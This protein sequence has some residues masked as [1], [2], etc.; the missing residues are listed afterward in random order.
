MLLPITII[1]W[2]DASGPPVEQ[3]IGINPESIARIEPA[4]TKGQCNVWCDRMTEPYLVKASAEELIGAI[5]LL[6]SEE[7]EC[8]ADA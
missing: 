4:E 3:Q 7:I 2:L 1:K 6:C 5:N 8:E